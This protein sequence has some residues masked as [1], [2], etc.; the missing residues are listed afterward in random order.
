MSG[1]EYGVSVTDGCVGWEETETILEQLAASVEARKNAVT[2][3]KETT[4]ITATEGRRSTVVRAIQTSHARRSSFHQLLEKFRRLS[5]AWRYHCSFLVLLTSDERPWGPESR[6]VLLIFLSP[7]LVFS[8][9]FSL[10]FPSS[11]Y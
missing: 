10:C 2:E 4:G 8:V 9:P 1:F 3:P 11:K 7:D 5:L 6:E